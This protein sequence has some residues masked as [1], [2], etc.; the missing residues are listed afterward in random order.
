MGDDFP[1]TEMAVK[2]LFGM[3]VKERRKVSVMQKEQERRE[4]TAGDLLDETQRQ[5]RIVQD[6]ATLKSDKLGRDHE[7]TL[8]SLM[9]AVA[10]DTAS[11][12]SAAAVSSSTSSL[13]IANERIVELQ[14]R[15]KSNEAEK[16]KLKAHKCMEQA[17]NVTLQQKSSECEVRPPDQS[18]LPPSLTPSNTTPPRRACTPSS[19]RPRRSSAPCARRRR[20]PRPVPASPTL[21]TLLRPRGTLR[22]R[23]RTRTSRQTTSRLRLGRTTS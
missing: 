19:T 14:K 17:L 5:I 18:A 16:Q 7:R 22:P 10:T 20:R 2:T 12:P 23:T 13:T 1:K 4:Q 11:S 15:L 8:S 6:E 21:P 9:L 3:V